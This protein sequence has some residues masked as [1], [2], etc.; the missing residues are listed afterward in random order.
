MTVPQHPTKHRLEPLFTARDF[1][2]YEASRTGSPV[3]PPPPNVVLVFGAR[4]ERRLDRAYRRTFEPRSG[5]YRVGA[6]VGIVR[7]P[8][9]GA[10]C[11]AIVVEEL[12]AL[13]VRNF[14]IVGLAGSLNPRLQAGSVVLC[15][16]ALRDEGTSYHYLRPGKFVAPDR[17]LT[18]RLRAALARVG[19]P[20]RAGPTWTID[21]PYRETVGEVR[22]YRKLGILTVEMEA[23]AVFAVTRCRRAAAAAL[24]VISDVLD[25]SG[26]EPR[27]RD[28]G[29]GLG[30]ALQVALDACARRRTAR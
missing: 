26:W 25:E 29:P 14:V 30:R 28:T 1:R 4:W 20:Y 23:S 11:S 27:F 17:G 19:D 10:P 3:P 22:R 7:V 16:K 15:T 21:A 12:I 9:P 8:G 13:G 2:R 18:R 24:F 6:G 5:V